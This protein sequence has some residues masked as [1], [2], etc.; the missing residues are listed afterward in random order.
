MPRPD[1]AWHLKRYAGRFLGRVVGAL[2]SL[3][4]LIG[5]GSSVLG[6]FNVLLLGYAARRWSAFGYGPSASQGTNAHL[7]TDAEG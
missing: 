3:L 6:V 1:P 4:V 2:W 5:L 7:E